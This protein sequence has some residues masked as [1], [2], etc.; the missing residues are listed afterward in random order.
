MAEAS[1]SVGPMAFQSMLPIT[2]RS[3]SVTV[4]CLTQRESA[5]P[6]RERTAHQRVT[7]GEPTGDLSNRLVLELGA[8]DPGE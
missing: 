6:W 3:I 1:P 4:R 8:V 2:R 5:T 7:L